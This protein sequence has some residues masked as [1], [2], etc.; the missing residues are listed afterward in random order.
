M[1]GDIFLLAIK[2]QHKIT[3]AADKIFGNTPSNVFC[4]TRNGLSAPV[5]RHS[6]SCLM[7]IHVAATAPI[8]IV[9]S[10]TMDSRIAVACSPTKK[11]IALPPSS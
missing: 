2:Y 1:I 6:K 9:P 7:L 4:N 8:T 10:I 5:C 11:S 3:N